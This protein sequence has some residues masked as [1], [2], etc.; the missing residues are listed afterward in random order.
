MYLEFGSDAECTQ[1]AREG[2]KLERYL[3]LQVRAPACGDHRENFGG[4]RFRFIAV[5]RGDAT[6]GE[7][8]HEGKESGGWFARGVTLYWPIP[9]L[10]PGAAPQRLEQPLVRKAAAA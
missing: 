9:R 7:V 10:G 6:I 1:T 5:D 4:A 3:V 8:V 2:Q